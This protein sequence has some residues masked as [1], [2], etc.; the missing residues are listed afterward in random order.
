MICS[1]AEGFRVVTVDMI[2]D[3]PRVVVAGLTITTAPTVSELHA[4]LG[5]PSRID[6]G[7]R[8]APVGHRNN[9]IHVYDGLGL[10]FNEHHYT[11]RAQAVCCW[12][13]TDEPRFR[14]TPQ[15]SFAGR[16]VFNGVVM[17]LGGD[18]RAFFTAAPFEFIESLGGVWSVRLAGFSI[19]VQAR[20]L[21]LRSGSRSRVRQIIEVSVSW[22]HD[23]W[24]PPADAEP[25]AA[26][27]GGAR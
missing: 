16:L 18:E 13:G 24:G 10:T 22:P 1:A 7:E 9:Q 25:G 3:G 6:N 26:A 20:G 14:F 5:P 11:R 8:P 21:R 4:V 2:P 23:N 12:F 27:D 15:Q 17:P 19:H